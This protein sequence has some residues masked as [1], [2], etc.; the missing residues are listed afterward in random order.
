MREISINLALE[1][2]L[3]LKLK[4][5]LKL[6]TDYIES[7]LCDSNEVLTATDCQHL[8][9]ISVTLQALSYPVLKQRLHARLLS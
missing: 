8:F 9:E 1:L 2:E 4:L 6:K 7:N 5:K 3:E